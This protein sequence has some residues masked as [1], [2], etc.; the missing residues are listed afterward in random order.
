MGK[1]SLQIWSFGGGGALKANRRVSVVSWGP[2]NV[3]NSLHGND[4]GIM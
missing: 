2:Q 1:R 3:K 4:D